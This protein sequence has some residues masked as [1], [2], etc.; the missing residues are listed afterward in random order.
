MISLSI[1]HKNVTRILQ[2]RLTISLTTLL[3][4]Y[5]LFS[6]TS[7]ALPK[8]SYIKMIDVWFFFCI[9]VLFSIII[10]H[11]VVGRLVVDTKTSMMIHSRTK[12]VSQEYVSGKNSMMNKISEKVL[13][14][15]QLPIDPPEKLLFLVR[16]YAFPLIVLPVT[17]IFWMVMRG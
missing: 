16:A 3:V 7:S 9:S 12:M 5:T 15:F 13:A 4:L 2:V 11:V 8:T 17:I 10:L 14:A 1:L 6:Q